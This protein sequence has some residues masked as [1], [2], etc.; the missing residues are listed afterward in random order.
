MN[1]RPVQC[2]HCDYALASFSELIE[3]LE[4]G[5]KCLLCGG[6]I[7][8]KELSTTADLFS[9]EDIAIE[10]RDK[11]KA[12]AGIAQ[13]EDLLESSPDFGDEGEDEAD[14]VL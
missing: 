12:E 8:K 7:E 3:A 6:L 4:G 9:A 14:P 2:P 10:G 5:G 11:A 1:R 13:E